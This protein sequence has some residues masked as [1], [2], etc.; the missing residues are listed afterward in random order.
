MNID[1]F[2]EYDAMVKEEAAEKAA[3]ALRQK[4][5]TKHAEHSPDPADAEASEPEASAEETPEPEAPAD[6][7]EREV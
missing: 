2:A 3:E 5:E 7:S 4:T 1:I 6:D